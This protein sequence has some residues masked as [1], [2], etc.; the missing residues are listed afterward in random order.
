MASPTAAPA[1]APIAPRSNTPVCAT[2]VVPFRC[3]LRCPPDA[4]GTAGVTAP[5][6]RR[7]GRSASGH[8][9]PARG[10]LLPELVERDLGAEILLER[11][12][13]D[14]GLPLRVGSRALERCHGEVLAH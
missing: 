10:Q 3:L 11:R 4:G 12:S 8:L 7:S 9:S 2:T 6:R 13:G 1:S 5:S 14:L